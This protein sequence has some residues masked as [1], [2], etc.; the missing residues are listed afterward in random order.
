ME[1][2]VTCVPAGG[3]PF[4]YQITP[5]K[6]VKYRWN[7]PTASYKVFGGGTDSDFFVLLQFPTASPNGVADTISVQVEL[8][9]CS[10]PVTK[11]T[12]LVSP[13]PGKPTIHGDS[14]VCE[15]DEGISYN[16]TPNNYPTSS[17]SWE[18]RKLSDNSQGGAFISDGQAT[19]KI[20]VNFLTED[21][22]ISVQESNSI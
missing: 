20:L 4:L 15:N 13:T 8:N 5:I 1:G 10:A 17:Y 16:V 3:V 18:I 2:S 11:K 6:G 12:I 14:V 19:N 21:V 7:I 22:V 9:G